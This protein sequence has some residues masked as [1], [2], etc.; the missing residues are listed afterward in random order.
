MYALTSQRHVLKSENLFVGAETNKGEGVNAGE[1][2]RFGNRL[3]NMKSRIP[4]INGHCYMSNQN[5]KKL[6]CQ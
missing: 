1:L 4:S 6:F 2:N 5:G 3:N